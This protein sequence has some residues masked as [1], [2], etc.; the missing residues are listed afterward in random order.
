MIN[1]FNVDKEK[2]I[3]LLILLIIL[4]EGLGFLSGFLGMASSEVYKELIKPT[5]SPPGWVFSIVWTI[6]YFLMAVSLYRII[7]IGKKGQNVRRGIKYF[8]IQFVL[9]FLWSII[10]FR[11][12][13]YGLA[14]IELMILLIFI[15]LTTFEFYKN[16]KIAAYLMI[17]YIIWVSFAGV[18]NF[19][20]WMLNEM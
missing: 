19:S 14:F 3:K 17:P 9:N 12:K 2:N 20:I 16:D 13:L 15:I 11:F 18:L 5:F 6:L 10:F 7:L 4:I 1:I 8:I